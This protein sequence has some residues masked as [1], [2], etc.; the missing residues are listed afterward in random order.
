MLSLSRLVELR[1]RFE[2]AGVR[3]AI[4][5]LSCGSGAS[6]KLATGHTCVISRSS[7]N[8][9]GFSDFSRALFSAFKPGSTLESAYLTARESAKY[10]ISLIR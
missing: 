8:S 1:D 2:K 9:E 6:Q 7:A 10:S 3:L 4:L 5:D